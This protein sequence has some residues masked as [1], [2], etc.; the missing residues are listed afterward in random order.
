MALLLCIFGPSPMYLL[1]CWGSAAQKQPM[2][3]IKELTP[4]RGYFSFQWSLVACSSVEI[5]YSQQIVES[6]VR[7]FLSFICSLSTDLSFHS[8]AGH[9]PFSHCT[10][11]SLPCPFLEAIMFVKF[12]IIFIE[13]CATICV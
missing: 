12:P 5:Q 3:F 2:L 8:R 1:L 4:G 9:Y 13:P 6:S 10:C 11:S 7:R